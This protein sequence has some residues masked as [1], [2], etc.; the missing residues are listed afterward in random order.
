M[1]DGQL[2][3]EQQLGIFREVSNVVDVIEDSEFTM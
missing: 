1:R 3:I 2:M